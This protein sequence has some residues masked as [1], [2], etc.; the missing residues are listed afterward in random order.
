MRY[1]K[2]FMLAVTLGLAVLAGRAMAKSEATQVA[3]FQDWANPDP[4]SMGAY[5]DS[6]GSKLNFTGDKGPGKNGKSLKL[7]YDLKAGGYCG[8][9]SNQSADLS[10][11]GKILVS[12]KAG[13]PGQAQISLK[14][15]WNV[16]Y[17]AK[18]QVP[19]KDWSVVKVDLSS[20]TKD[21]YTPD[22]AQVGHPMD[23]SQLNGMN[24]APLDPGV[25]TLWVGPVAIE[26][27]SAAAPTAAS[28]STGVSPDKPAPAATGEKVVVQDFNTAL[29][30]GMIGA[31]Q[32]SQGSTLVYGQ[33][34][35]PKAK[36]GDQAL[37]VS[38]DL[39]AGGYCGLWCRAGD[40]WD[41]VNLQGA[42]TLSFMIYSKAPVQVGVALKDKNNNQ[43]VA[44]APAS[45]GKGWE[46]VTVPMSSF[47]LDPYYTP[48]D[49]V[50]GAPMD[51][52]QVKTFNLA[53][54]TV[55]KFVVLIDNIVAAK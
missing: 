44:D 47:I 27:G 54:K 43:F 10:K 28:G 53:P 17:T 24:F 45:Q 19:S 42:Q 31:Y 16:Q 35:A 3:P 23:L 12:V 1:G 55:G 14:D 30:S 6:Q 13:K 41:G 49:A 51:L 46:T 18:F 11:A 34:A 38:Y 26:A 25:G 2:R 21:S 36:K 33:K 5:A 22:G 48:S 52:S 40:T 37:E 15:K 4:S 32:D 29:E 20:F 39:K 8:L 9:W 7:D 50:K